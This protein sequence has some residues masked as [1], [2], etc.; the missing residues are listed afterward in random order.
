QRAHGQPSQVVLTVPILEGLDGVQKMSKSLNNA[1]GIAEPPKEMYGKLMSISDEL[2]WKYW[3]L[4]TDVPEEKIEVLKRRC[5]E[6]EA[7][8]MK[9]KKELA[10]RITQDFHG[11]PAGLQ[12]AADWKTQFQ[13][14]EIPEHIET[15]DVI[16]EKIYVSR[17]DPDSLSTAFYDV[18]IKQKWNELK[19]SH[20][21]AAI[22]T[23]KLL[24]EAGLAVSA[25]EAGRKRK[26]R[27]V[28]I[29]GEVVAAAQ[30]G[31]FIPGELLLG[32]GRRLKKVRV[33]LK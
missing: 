20:F 8:P 25:A 24:V 32:V 17:T 13:K 28:K 16:F 15:V 1:I 29:G 7:H 22:R 27:A 19:N 3:L 21:P 14:S 5:A 23:D 11:E 2:M 12:A 18:D 30:I 31:K 33:S 10:K 6:G 26:E 9:V 4:L